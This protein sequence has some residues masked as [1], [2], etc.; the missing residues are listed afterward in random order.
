MCVVLAV[1]VGLLLFFMVRLNHRVL[2]QPDAG[3]E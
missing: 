1:L 3:N 2:K